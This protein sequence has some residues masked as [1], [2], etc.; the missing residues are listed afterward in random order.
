MRNII[1]LSIAFV[2]AFVTVN[3][4]PPTWTFDPAHSNLGFSIMRLMISDV[5]GTLRISELTLST[6]NEDFTDASVSLVIDA[7]SID[8]DVDDRDEHLKSPDLFD[9][10]K[11]P[12][13]TFK[14]TSFKKSGDKEY[15]IA[16][17]FTMHGVTKPI[18][19]EAVVN[20]TYDTYSKKNVTG[21][22]VTGVVK[23]LD[24]GI[25]TTTPAAMLSDEVTL[26]ANIVVVKN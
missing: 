17:D 3:A 15:T 9:T 5:T 4:A 22:R 6:V 1:T 2:F 24:F 7:K 13:M 8:T 18:T 10:G 19:L 23:R 20:T 21:F 12:T 25:A 14:S 16:G 26:T 11:Y